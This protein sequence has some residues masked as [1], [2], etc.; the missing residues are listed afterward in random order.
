MMVIYD[1]GR[2]RM[3]LTPSRNLQHLVLAIPGLTMKM[4]EEN[5]KDIKES[6]NMVIG[7]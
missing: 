6:I 2:K 3:N 4:E 7:L 5:T 1:N